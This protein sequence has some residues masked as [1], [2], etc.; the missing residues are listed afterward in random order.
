MTP[1]QKPGVAQ[2]PWVV[3]EGVNIRPL[4]IGVRVHRACKGRG[5]NDHNGW[6]QYATTAFHTPTLTIVNP[7]NTYI[8]ALFNQH[9]GTEP[10]PAPY[11]MAISMVIGELGAEGEAGCSRQFIDHSAADF[12]PT[13]T[14]HCRPL[15]RAC[16]NL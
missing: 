3:G 6:L 13:Y 11:S 4:T 16:S 7:I 1:P 10:N 14:Q 2:P 9:T 15:I 5:D 8:T 12:P